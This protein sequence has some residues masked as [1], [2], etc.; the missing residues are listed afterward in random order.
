VGHPV[1]HIK[2]T[3]RDNG[4]RS[5]K[6]TLVLLTQLLIFVGALLA[7]KFDVIVGLYPTMVGGLLG[8]L[9]VYLTGQV[10]QS[11][12]M[13]GHLTSVVGQMAKP[14][15]SEELPEEPK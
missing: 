13:G 9:T 15:E 10:Y 3:I 2:E 1:E 6:F 12:K 7:K 4:W 14:E 11:T 8:G 5:R